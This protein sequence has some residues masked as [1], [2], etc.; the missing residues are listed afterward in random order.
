MASPPQA[1]YRELTPAALFFGVL[2]GTVMTAAFVYVALRLG[3]TLPGSTVAAILGFAVL[4]GIL[5]RGS[6]IEN[7][8]NQTVASGVNTASAGVAFTLP[9]LFI[10]GA[11]DPSLRHFSVLPIL[12]AAIGG[13]FLGIVFIIPLRKQMVELERLRFPS[14]IA[15]AS[16][17]KSPGAG[18]R[19]AK[20]LGGGF[21]VAAL[22]HVSAGVEALPAWLHLPEEL[23]F[24]VWLGIPEYIPI[25]L[26]VSFASLGA[27]LLSGRGGLPFVF[28]G[29]LAWWVLAPI[30]VGLD[31]VPSPADMHL[32]AMPEGYDS[33]VAWDVL[34]AQMLRPLG[35][36]ILIGGALSGV[37]A[38]APAL[39]AALK[40][41]SVASKTAGAGGADE[42]SPRVLYGG[43]AVA[44]L[45]LL[46]AS[47]LS[48]SSIGIG[49]AV[50][51]AGVGT[52]WLGLAGLIVAQATGMTDISPISGMSLIGV[53]LMFFLSGG[54]VVASIV[55]GVAVSMGIGQ[56][57]DMMSD[58]KSGHLIGASPRKQ[59]LAQF[60]LAW[61]GAPVAVGVL[62]L[63]WGSF[64]HPGF[65]PGTALAAPQGTALASII[66]ALRA[67]AAPLDKYVAGSAI[68]LGLGVFP[69]GGIG[70]LVGLAMYLPFAITMTYGVGC[71]VSMGLE[72]WKGARWMGDTLV[73]VAA[74]FI[75]G[76]AL[77]SL[78]IVLVRLATGG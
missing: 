5:R 59:Q 28:G 65:G 3:F 39:R 17:L 76:E 6:I 16:L 12:L 35:I 64:D 32:A 48:D 57:A 40:G 43:I 21:L 9:A 37:I 41:L 46:A 36:G 30:A 54:N 18:I 75:I 50:L 55:L 68:G 23:T 47:V 66:D 45:V 63:L 38:S 31:W 74:G 60:W 52:V 15:V 2:I 69:I 77:T 27:G 29:M 4:R 44:F 78:T 72:R 58:L 67:G 22:F 62:Y 71:F 34:Y 26:S 7:N 33:F 8:V 73:P 61:I 24:G 53:T 14:G 10:L 19:Q 20:L 70:V 42:M 1:P 51:T 11:R 13:S 49:R 56:C 25:A